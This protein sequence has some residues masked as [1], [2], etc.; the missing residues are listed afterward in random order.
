MILQNA[1][2]ILLEIMIT[3]ESHTGLM[4]ARMRL[5]HVNMFVT[6]ELESEKDREPTSRP[7]MQ[8]IKYQSSPGQLDI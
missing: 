1:V 3:M 2:T 7:S 6:T 5:A 8:S 4:V